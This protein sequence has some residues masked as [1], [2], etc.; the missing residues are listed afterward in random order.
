MQQH[1]GYHK[2]HSVFRTLKAAPEQPF[3]IA[4]LV[5]YRVSV[6]EH[7]RCDR[8]DAAVIQQILL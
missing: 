1:A 7:F 5:D 8:L 3:Y 6:H 4:E 2:F